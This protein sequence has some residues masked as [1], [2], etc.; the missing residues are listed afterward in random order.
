MSQRKIMKTVLAP[1]EK[2]VTRDGHLGRNALE[3][4]ES[5]FARLKECR[6]TTTIYVSGQTDSAL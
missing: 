1:Q 4:Q 3:N 6:Y 2:H 5:A